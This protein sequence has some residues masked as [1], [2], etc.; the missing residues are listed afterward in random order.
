MAGR[1]FRVVFDIH[2]VAARVH[3][4]AFRVDRDDAGGRGA[5]PFLVIGPA[6]DDRAHRDRVA[7]GVL[8]QTVRAEGERHVAR[9][10]AEHVLAQVVA[11]VEDD[12][13]VQLDVPLHG[14]HRGVEQRALDEQPLAVRARLEI[15]AAGHVGAHDLLAFEQVGLALLHGHVFQGLVGEHGFQVE[16]EPERFL[17]RG[18]V[19]LEF[20]GDFLRHHAPQVGAD[21]HVHEETLLAEV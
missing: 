5:H 6:G 14:L 11:L 10:V 1:P 2:L 19:A 9:L 8:A 17:L 15:L 4:L 13:A 3:G 20:S 7:C 12:A 18:G 16:L 21:H